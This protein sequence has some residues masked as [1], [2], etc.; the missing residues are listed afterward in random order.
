MLNKLPQE[1]VKHALFSVLSYPQL[2]DMDTLVNSSHTKKWFI[3]T[4]AHD[5]G[6]AS[7]EERKG[8]S[9]TEVQKL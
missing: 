5:S 7:E 3:R 9:K 8:V 4:W 2:C 1:F 6:R